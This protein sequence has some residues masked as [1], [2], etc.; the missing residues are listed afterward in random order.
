M[1]PASGRTWRARTP[2]AA[3][4]AAVALALV[5]LAGGCQTQ[6]WVPPMTA[7]VDPLPPGENAVA[8]GL[9]EVLVVRHSDPVAVRDPG[10]VGQVPV[11]YREK[12]RRVAGGGAI[13]V[14]S[15]GRAEVRWP[16][17]DTEILLVE[18]CSLRVGVRE[19]GEPIAVLRDPSRARIVLGGGSHLRLEGFCDVI[20]P[21]GIPS[22]PL[23]LERP[24][25]DLLRFYNSGKRA[26][27]LDVGGAP[28]VVGASQSI[29]LPQLG[30]RTI[31]DQTE[32]NELANVLPTPQGELRWEAPVVF[33]P[34]GGGVRFSTE[35]AARFAAVGSVWHL[36]PPYSVVIATD[37]SRPVGVAPGS[38]PS[39]P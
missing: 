37:P 17:E 21:E 29:D 15:S 5:A 35:S 20:A 16:G 3:R 4:G 8:R 19:R 14:G 18:S 24:R 10:S 23:R 2:E 31:A 33:A 9:D 7:S 1:S 27:R 30:S 34:V 28:V 11:T 13:H 12:R 25:V 38:S 39:A 36:E 22:G 32:R 6:Q 26:V